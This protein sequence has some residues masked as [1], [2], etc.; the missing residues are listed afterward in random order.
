M[1]PG[2]KYPQRVGKF[3]S[4]L[5]AKVA[6]SLDKR[7]VKYEYEKLRLPF[8]PKLRHYNPDFVLSNGIIIEVKGEFTSPDRAK[9]IA[10]QKQHPDRD[11][12]FC[13]GYAKAKLYPGSKSTYASWCIQHGFQFCENHVPDSWLEEQSSP[14]K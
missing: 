14:G 1:K 2:R 6:M 3:R 4:R 13:F 9:H 5:E 10:I 11:I 12:R 7:G 8:I